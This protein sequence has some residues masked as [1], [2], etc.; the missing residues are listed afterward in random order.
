MSIKDEVKNKVNIVDLVSE[1][2]TLKR[3]GVNY[4]GLCPFHNEK[5]PSFIVSEEKQIFHCFGCGAGGD[6]YEFLMKIEGLD[7]YKAIKLLGDKV[8]VKVEPSGF[9]KNTVK[10]S[11]R[12]LEILNLTKIFYHKL[13][14][15]H[16][17]ADIARKYL[18]ERSR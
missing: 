11:D 14:L 1:Y 18:D 7:F 15:N 16:E 4:K 9:K 17:K 12:T 8:G 13:L 10:N 3:A 2:V 5:S 6:V